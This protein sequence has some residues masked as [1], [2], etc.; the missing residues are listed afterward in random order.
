VYRLRS[1]DEARAQVREM[2][3]HHPD[4]VKLWLDDM[5]GKYPK[6]DPAIC[7]AVIEESHRLGL[8]VAAHVFYLADAKALIAGWCGRPRAQ[9]SRL[10]R[11]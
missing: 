10:A 7:K 3:Q 11:R 5:Y 6:M 4:I 9:H 1:P 2:A 8:R